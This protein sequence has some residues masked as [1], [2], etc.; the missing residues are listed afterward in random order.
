[1]YYN[2]KMYNYNFK[3]TA[4]HLKIALNLNK[5]TPEQ[6]KADLKLLQDYIRV[7]GLL[8]RAIKTT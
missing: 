4:K 2:Y 7:E 8:R 3:T 6:K 1:M 5:P